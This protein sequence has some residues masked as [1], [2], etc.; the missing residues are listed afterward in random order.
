M[1]VRAAIFAVTASAAFVGMPTLAH[2]SHDEDETKLMP[3]ACA[4]LG[5]AKRYLTDVAYPEV[6]A[7][8]T[9]CDNER[10]SANKSAQPAPP[11]PAEKS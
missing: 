5:D 1:K 9:R 6:K 3:S 4:H 7:L 10:K 2:E 11:K 8:K